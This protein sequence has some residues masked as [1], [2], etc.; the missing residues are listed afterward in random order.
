MLTVCGLI[1]F[2]GNGCGTK[3]TYTYWRVAQTIESDQIQN[4]LETSSD[5][6]LPIKE[7]DTVGV[8]TKEEIEIYS[9]NVN[10]VIMVVTS[11]NSS[12]LKGR[13]EHYKEDVE[14]KIFE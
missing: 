4:Y 10:R 13:V 12:I 6:E 3:K 5:K 1:V 9:T 8:N 11:V 7:G 2:A 14:S